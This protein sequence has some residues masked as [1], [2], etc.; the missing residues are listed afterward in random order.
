MNAG[1]RLLRVQYS[2]SLYIKSLLLACLLAGVGGSLRDVPAADAP[3]TDKQNSRQV[4]AAGDSGSPQDSRTPE[5]SRQRKIR[6]AGIVTQFRHNSHA[7]M[8]CGRLMEGNNLNGQPPYPGLELVSLY[9]DQPETSEYG[10]EMAKKH[11]VP[12]FDTIEKALQRGGDAL[13]VDGVLM[14]AE[15]GDY[16]QDDNDQKLYPKLR[17]FTAISKV[18]EQSG[19]QIPVFSDKHLSH[20][21]SEAD[22][23]YRTARRLKLPFMAG[24]SLPSYRRTPSVDVPRGAKLEQ[25]ISIGYGRNEAYGF[26]ALEA[27][28]CLAE[29]RQ[30]GETGVRAVRTLSGDAVWQAGEDGLYDR[31]L[32]NAAIA[33]SPSIG[34]RGKP[35]EQAVRKPVLM[36]IEYRDGLRGFL[37]MLNGVARRFTVAWKPG[38]ATQLLPENPPAPGDA[39]RAGAGNS[40][41]TVL[42]D[43][44]E[45][46]PF[47]HFTYLLE[48]VEQMMHTGKPAWPVE[49]TLLT[50]GILNAC[51]ISLAEDGRTVETPYLDFR[52]NS[53]W[54]WRQP[55]PPIV[56]KPR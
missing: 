22:T 21:W 53:D 11:G 20:T 33:A 24:S 47:S 15:H 5:A 19:R 43:I 6:V 41:A 37:F 51:L 42:F 4:A 30:G 54:D 45:V 29:R 10:L 40:H 35:L 36:V 56:T 12:V 44:Q 50:T 27:L 17:L 28:Q 2:K 34:G 49:R 46:R 8:I 31:E 48:G 7:E 25:I 55:P 52:Y 32:L 9:I 13:A 18:I 3:R 14:V 26:H 16:P 1:P 39:P 38:T 23:I